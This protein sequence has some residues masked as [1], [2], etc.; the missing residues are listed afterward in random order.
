MIYRN[1]QLLKIGLNRSY[2]SPC[3]F[4][5]HCMYC[6][7]CELYK[8]SSQSLIFQLYAFFKG[9]T[10]YVYSDFVSIN[11][12]LPGAETRS[13]SKAWPAATKQI[14][15]KSRTRPA[16]EGRGERSIPHPH[17]QLGKRVGSRVRFAQSSPVPAR[18]R[19]SAGGC[20]GCGFRA[21]P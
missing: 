7:K 4:H 12:A 16:V 10:D 6:I 13:R 17:R 15:S 14:K 11:A 18:P 8:A 2:I 20:A 19:W 21:G 1:F 9:V 3:I 5:K